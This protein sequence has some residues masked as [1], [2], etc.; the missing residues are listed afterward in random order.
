MKWGKSYAKGGQ[1]GWSHLLSFSPM[2]KDYILGMG[3]HPLALS[4]LAWRCAGFSLSP[5]MC[6]LIEGAVCLPPYH[7]LG[8]VGI[9]LLATAALRT[10]CNATSA[11]KIQN[12]ESHQNGIQ[13]TNT[14]IGNPF[15]QSGNAG[16]GVQIN[17]KI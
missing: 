5:G 3:G 13:H 2:L 15:L 16:S 1:G 17:P 9:S 12:C 11:M 6:F 7:L 4:S 8:R 10:L 14:G